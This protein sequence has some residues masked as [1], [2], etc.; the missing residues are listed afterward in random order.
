MNITIL[1]AHNRE[2]QQ[3]AYSCLLID[4]V[5]A[6]D[7]GA[8]TSRLPLESQLALRAVLLTHR[9]F[10]H[11]RDLPGL[12]MNFYA[13][14]A[15]IDLLATEETRDDVAAFLF[16]GQHYPNFLERPPEDPTVRFVT[17]EAFR[18]TNVGDLAVLPVP[19]AH[20]APSVG[21]QVTSADGKSVLYTSDTGPGLAESWKRVKPRLLVVEVTL[22]NGAEELAET[23]GHLTPAL[24]QQEMTVFRE[25]HGY[26][27]QIVTTHMDIGMEDDIQLQLDDVAVALNHPISPAYEGMLL[28]L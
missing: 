20:A 12:A 14:G 13:T 6:I 19:M 9:H 26:L 2:T 16:D 22:P 27:P 3:A 1:G 10:D 18:E 28:Q 8:L 5:L 23:A 24:L 21:Y 4:G 25:I 15:S 7:A 17:V 11:V